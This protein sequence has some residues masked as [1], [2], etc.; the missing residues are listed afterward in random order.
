MSEIPSFILE[1]EIKEALPKYGSNVHI[2]NYWGRHAQKQSGEVI[3][4]GEL[5]K[6]SISQKGANESKE[7]GKKIEAAK[8]GAKAYVS[9][10][11]RAR[12][13]AESIL[14]GYQ[15]KNPDVPIR[16]IVIRE[17]LSSNFPKEF[18]EI[19]DGRFIESRTKLMQEMGLEHGLFKQLSPDQQEEIAERAEEPV[20][21][22]WL[23]GQS[24]LSQLLTP[25][26]ASR[27]FA[28][29]F[30]RRH[31][32]MASKLY[33]GSEVDLIHIT[34][35]GIMEPFLVSGVLINQD[36]QR[37]TDIEELGGSLAIM[38]GW[39]SEMKTDNQGNPI[40]TVKLR[41]KTYS[42]DEMQLSKVVEDNND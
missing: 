11:P 18:L 41:E 7:V 10:S 6:S 33:S 23:K 38:E 29:L 24:G 5:S 36:G 9:Q 39:E 12:E 19:Y 25:K 37:V 34:H 27:T 17:K 20:L 8:N 40:T 4:A 31:G 30:N 26:Q 28:Q 16:K 13:T 1:E 21:Q 14:E 3:T 35:R 2:R 42:I 22:E 32:R 15:E